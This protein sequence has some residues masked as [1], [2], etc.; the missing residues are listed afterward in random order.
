MINKNICLSGRLFVVFMGDK[1]VLYKFI[2]TFFFFFFVYKI[3]LLELPI[4]HI[5]LKFIP[6]Y[7]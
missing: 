1:L 4:L 5:D 2:H 3:T 6:Y 7:R